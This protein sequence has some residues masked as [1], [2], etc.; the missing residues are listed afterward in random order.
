MNL[1]KMFFFLVGLA[2]KDEND[3][4]MMV[5]VWRLDPEWKRKPRVSFLEK[6]IA[7]SPRVIQP[8]TL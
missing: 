7:F 1:K 6:P 3:L 5:V 4:K 2:E 8:P